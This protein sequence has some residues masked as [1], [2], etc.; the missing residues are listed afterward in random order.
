MSR[1]DDIQYGEHDQVVLPNQ[2]GDKSPHVLDL[3]K[4][5]TRHTHDYKLRDVRGDLKAGLEN[6]RKQ[7][8]EKRDHSVKVAS[9]FAESMRMMAI[10]VVAVFMLNVVGVYYQGVRL[11]NEIATAAYS[12]YESIMNEGPSPD[13]F[14]LAQNNFAQAQ[15]SLWFLQNQRADLRDQ[16]KAASAISNMLDAGEELSN[17]GEYF[18]KF[19]NEAKAVSGK[20]FAPKVVGASA[21]GE[22]DE[23]YNEYF[24]PALAQLNIA[25]DRIQEIRAGVFPAELQPTVVK[26]QTELG[27]LTHV[28]TEFSER[29]PL[30]MRLLGDDHPQRYLVLLENN[31]ESRPGGGFIGSYMLVDLNDGYL[32]GMTFHDVY[33]LDNRYHKDIEPP[34]EVAKLTNNWRFRDS[35]YSPDMSVS[36]AKSAWFLDEEGGPSVDHVVTVDLAFV[37]RMLDITGP[38]KIDAL[39]IALASDNFSTVLSYMVEAKL[40]GATTP[41]QVLAEFIDKVQ[42]TLKEDAPWVELVAVM[43]D[44]SRSKHLSIYSKNDDIQTF[45]QDFGMS[46]VVPTRSEKEDH[47]MLVHTTIGNKTDAYVT[48]DIEHISSIDT[49]G[50]IIDQVNVS[51]TH[52]WNDFERL[53][54]KNLLASF[55]FTDPDPWLIDLLGGAA[56]TSVMR[57][58]VPHGTRLLHTSGVRMEDVI[59]EYDKDLDLDYFTFSTTVFPD[60]KTDFSLTYELPFDL[61]FEP[62]DEYRLNVSK[63]PS[64]QGTTFTKVIEG[65]VNLTHYRSFPE[66]LLENAHEQGIGVYQWSTDLTH[67]LHLA[68]LW[69][70]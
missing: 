34:G 35:N 67:D 56:N 69:G 70:R 18:V 3:S 33:D 43:H 68:Q 26:A 52:H 62:L 9:R 27:E 7:Y 17:S 40:T 32:D 38:I 14:Q 11:K 29:Y 36:A 54:L 1:F 61:N 10:G 13:A 60:S 4:I 30:F 42:V 44:M 5:K 2:E 63:Q 31:N 16:S 12:S 8:E 37:S 58:Y 65:G 6:A 28:L 55:G 22:L 53:R 15:E 20:F 45:F 46:G 64:D 19:V 21:T 59:S 57:L 51:R 25:N 41:K 24:V 47:F 23:A 48:Q 66:E 39:P 50:G 49:N